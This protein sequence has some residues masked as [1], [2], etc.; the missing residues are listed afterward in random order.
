VNEEDGKLKWI[1][2]KYCL[3]LTFPIVK[4]KDFVLIELHIYFILIKLIL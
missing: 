4:D 1:A 3:E 2:E